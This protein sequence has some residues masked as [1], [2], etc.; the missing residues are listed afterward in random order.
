MN[1]CALQLVWR[2]NVRTTRS[3]S[4]K[5][6]KDKKDPHMMDIFPTG[7]NAIKD[8]NS[9]PPSSEG[10]WLPTDFKISISMK[11][12]RLTGHEEPYVNKTL[13]IGL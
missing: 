10:P 11:R 7:G 5:M 12:N 1:C 8:L 9:G 3:V 4:V 6:G 13:G 2:L